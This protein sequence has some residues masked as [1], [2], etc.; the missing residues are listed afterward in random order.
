[1]TKYNIEIREILGFVVLGYTDGRVSLIS[2]EN[3]NFL[4]YHVAKFLAI[5]PILEQDLY[6]LKKQHS[7]ITITKQPQDLSFDRFWTVYNYKVGKKAK[8]EKLWTEMSLD[9]RSAALI[10]VVKYNKWMNQKSIE[11]AYPETWL[12]QKRWE[13]EYKF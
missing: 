12:N 7:N 11:K 10:A 4:N 8:A 5:F 3:S 13:N 1:M 6:I 2:F 9:E